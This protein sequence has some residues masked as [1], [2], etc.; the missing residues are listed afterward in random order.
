MH[1]LTTLP[2]ISTRSAVGLVRLEGVRMRQL[3]RTTEHAPVT[4]LQTTSS[5]YC[6]DGS[7]IPTG[8]V[9]HGIL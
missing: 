4:I 3:K 7:D 2:F 8:V 6:A 5:P 9:H 1:D